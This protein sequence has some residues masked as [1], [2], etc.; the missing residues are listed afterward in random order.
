MVLLREKGDIQV[1]I[2]PRV[3]SHVITVGKS[4]SKRTASVSVTSLISS[5][6]LSTANE[7]KNAIVEATINGTNITAM[8]DIGSSISFIDERLC[9]TL[10][11]KLMPVEGKFFMDSTSL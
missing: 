7:F 10:Q 11:L 6:T 2:A 5:S 1:L 8:S 4:A 3:T 9:K